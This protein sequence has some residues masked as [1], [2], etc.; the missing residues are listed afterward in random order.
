MGFKRSSLSRLRR[1]SVK[2]LKGWIWGIL[3]LIKIN[4]KEV[5]SYQEEF[6]STRLF[7]EKS[8]PMMFYV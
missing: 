8:Q 5:R 4:K 1:L 6:I 2:N 7:N 3:C